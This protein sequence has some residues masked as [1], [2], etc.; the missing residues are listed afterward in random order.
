M[1]T[2]TMMEEVVVAG[3]AVVDV[4]CSDSTYRSE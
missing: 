4:C 3:V 2:K 1:M